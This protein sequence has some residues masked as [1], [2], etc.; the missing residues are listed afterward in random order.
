MPS[1]EDGLVRSI[2]S[3]AW[4][5]FRHR[6]LMFL[7]L[8]AAS[9]PLV[10]AYYF[11]VPGLLMITSSARTTYL[12]LLVAGYAVCFA[13]VFVLWC[14]GV[15]L[16]DGSVRK[17]GETPYRGAFRG[18]SLLGRPVLWSGLVLGLVNVFVV[19]FS[20]MAVG[21][22]IG[23]VASSQGS[24]ANQQILFYVMVYLSYIVA[25]I[26]LV[27][28]VLVPQMIALEGG[29][30]VD[31]VIRASYLVIKERYRDAVM[32]L[33]VPELVV[34]TLFIA[35][36]YA[37]VLVPGNYAIFAF[38]LF[39]ALLEGGRLAYTTAAFNRFYYHVLEE[40]KKKKKSGKQA[41]AKKPV[42]K[43]APGKQ[44][45]REKPPGKQAQKKPVG[46]RAGRR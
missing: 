9:L 23:F 34:R 40:E 43:Q 16:Y 19:Q 36:L 13:L 5:D 21:F 3:D 35:S 7:L 20:Q 32:L 8:A 25:D 6:P 22:L 31:E 33:I 15:L 42:Q 38:L 1:K 28:V 44:Q 29:K 37:I 27:L 39:M 4:R 12:G 18:V 45:A 26:M 14:A 10:F 17:K 24:S 46:K 2:L 11:C 41:A 30:K